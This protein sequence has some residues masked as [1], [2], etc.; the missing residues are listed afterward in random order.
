MLPTILYI[1]ESPRE[2]ANE[3]CASMETSRFNFM[4][5]SVFRGAST[6]AVSAF[7]EDQIEFLNG[8]P[9]Y[10]GNRLFKCFKNRSNGLLF[11]IINDDEFRWAFYNDMNDYNVKVTCTAGA[12]SHV[13]PLGSTTMAINASTREKVLEVT[14][15][16]LETAMFL[17]GV[18]KG[19]KLRYEAQPI[20]RSECLARKL[21]I[22]DFN[23]LSQTMQG[24]TDDDSQLQVSDTK[25]KS[26]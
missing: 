13:T 12:D 2:E 26:D 17:D 3:T 25:E 14:V 5:D 15:G 18:L 1:M 11:R 8:K 20:P 16:P 24:V 23:A 21:K 22:T 6:S 9:T 7:N 19:C 4:R 10:K